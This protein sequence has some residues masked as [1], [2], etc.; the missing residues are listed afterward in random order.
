MK[1]KFCL[2]MSAAMILSIIAPMTNVALQKN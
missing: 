1:R 2:V